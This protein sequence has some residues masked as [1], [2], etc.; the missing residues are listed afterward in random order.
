MDKKTQR[1]LIKKIRDAMT[2]EERTA[3]S[4]KICLRLQSLMSTLNPSVIFSYLATPE[5]VELRAFH[6]WAREQGF[7]L[8]YP[9][10]YGKGS[11]EAYVPGEACQWET[12]RYGIRVPKEESARRILP[13]EISLILSPCVAFDSEC[14]RLGHGGG[15]YDR[16]FARCPNALR[17]GVAFEAQRLPELTTGPYD[18]SLHG[19]LTEQALYGRLLW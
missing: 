12:D 15:Y 6:H 16:Y 14:R 17:L 5:E 8:A 4:E 11:M 3:A 2:P 7:T 13:E 9:I 1:L 18:V 19:V 10:T